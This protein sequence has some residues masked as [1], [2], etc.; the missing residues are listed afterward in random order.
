M[1]GLIVSILARKRNDLTGVIGSAPAYEITNKIVYDLYYVFIIL[2]Y[3]F[4]YLYVPNK[5]GENEFPTKEVRKAFEDDPLVNS[6]KTY[7]KTVL[8]MV[9]YNV[10]DRIEDIHCPFLLIQGTNDQSVTLR[11]AQQKSSHLKHPKSEFILYNDC[12]HCLYEEHN[13]EDQLVNLIRWI[14]KVRE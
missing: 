1:G 12:V 3:F 5:Y 10:I 13:L 11:G 9:K 7:L 4:P 2:L 14:D 6:D 8:E